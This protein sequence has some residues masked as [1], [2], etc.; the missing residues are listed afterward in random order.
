MENKLDM[1]NVLDQRFVK[2]DKELLKQRE[3]IHVNRDK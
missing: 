1:F 2:F 3:L